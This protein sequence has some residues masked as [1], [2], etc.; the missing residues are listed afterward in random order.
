[1]RVK[2]LEA[3]WVALRLE[4]SL[5]NFMATDKHCHLENKNNKNN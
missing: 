2:P 1:M 4:V 3:D 5:T